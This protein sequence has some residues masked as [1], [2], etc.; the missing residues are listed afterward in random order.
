[1]QNLILM[2]KYYEIYNKTSN[3][4]QYKDANLPAYDPY[5]KDKM[6][7]Q[8]SYFWHGNPHTWKDIFNI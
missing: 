1:M 2:K 3:L 5:V 4:S 6:I 8:L 7:L